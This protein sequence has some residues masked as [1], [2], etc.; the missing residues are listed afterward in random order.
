LTHRFSKETNSSTPSAVSTVTKT[1]ASSAV[2]S[3]SGFE[4]L[5]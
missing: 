2:V 1:A 5:P 3:C 4:P